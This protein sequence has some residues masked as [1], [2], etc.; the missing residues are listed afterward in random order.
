MELEPSSEEW[1]QL[2]FLEEE[3][4]RPETR[5]DRKQMEELFAPDLVEF[6]RSCRAY[7]WDHILSVAVQEI[8]ASLPLEDFQIRMVGPDVALVTYDSDVSYSSGRERAHRSSFWT[9]AKAAARWQLRFHQ[10]PPIADFS[11]RNLLDV[12][13]S[14]AGWYRG[15]WEATRRARR[16]PRVR[17]EVSAPSTAAGSGAAVTSTL[18]ISRSLFPGG[19]PS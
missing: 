8:P 5:A 6:G 18:S 3:L 14:V 7:S 10:G 4:W 11:Y 19:P 15:Y 1:D 16:N 13:R 9:R 12:D 2:E 17:V